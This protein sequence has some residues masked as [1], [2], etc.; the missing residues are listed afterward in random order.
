MLVSAREGPATRKQF[1]S[2]RTRRQAP[3]DPHEICKLGFLSANPI[4][5]PLKP[6]IIIYTL[7]YKL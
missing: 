3:S 6:N 7:N 5:N 1:D 4:V 2:H